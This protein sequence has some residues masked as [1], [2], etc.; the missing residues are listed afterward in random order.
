MKLNHYPFLR[1]AIF[2]ISGVAFCFSSNNHWLLCFGIALIALLV[3]VSGY[4]KKNK[5]LLSAGL[6]TLFFCLGWGV[7]W[8]SQNKTNIP[9][10]E[11]IE[12]Y[13]VR[14][15]SAVE[16]KPK[17]YKLTAEV[18]GLRQEEHWEEGNF[19]LLLYFEKD[20]S[21]VPVYGDIFLI[22]GHPR[23]IE[24]PKNPYEFNYRDVQFKKS[25]FGHHFLRSGD[26]V[27]LSHKPKSFLMSQILSWNKKTG[28]ILKHIT[29][30]SENFGIAESMLTGTRDNLELEI[31]DAYTTT[32]AVHILAVS[33]MHV[34]ILV[35]MLNFFFKPILKTPSSRFYFGVISTVCIWLYAVFTGFSASV[36]RATLMF[37]M[38][39]LAGIFYLRKNSLNIL[40]A[41]AVVL[42]LVNPVWFLDVG[43]Q[44]S[45]L[46]MIGIIYLYPQ[47]Y[48]LLTPKNWFTDHLWQVSVMS[49]TAQLFTTPVSLYY[50]HQFPNYFLLTNVL[51]TLGSSG[52]LLF[53]IP[54]VLLSGV[55]VINQVLATLLS[56]TLYF[57]NGLI[58]A[59]ASLPYSLSTG[60]NV[61]LT[62]VMVLFLMILLAVWLFTEKEHKL[63]IPLIILSVFLF[64]SGVFQDLR[65]MKQREITF[66]FIP[67]GSG[68]SLISSKKAL[69]LCDSV[70][71]INPRAYSF[72]L[73][74]YYDTKGI[75][76]YQFQSPENI[77]G[78]SSFDF[79]GLRCLWIHKSNTDKIDEYFDVVMISNNAVFDLEKQ[80][81]TMPK[82]IILDDTNSQKRIRTLE[83]QAEKLSADF[84]SLYETGGFTL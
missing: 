62:E 7:T 77:S 48:P 73:R 2:F 1:I 4:I 69:F 64:G 50:F 49:L 9:E 43:F 83:S 14:V 28:E 65:Q 18:L 21:R 57:M 23:T 80:F 72:H 44:L 68:I 12:A 56:W 20:S 33:G 6:Y 61:S 16:V 34:G 19:D 26:F 35:M 27:F 22:I 10:F 81:I 37:S 79:E 59:I 74:N 38:F 8:Q 67:K 63:L 76:Q 53:G 29:D 30:S 47:V 58:K 51:V 24:G 25:I 3:F 42:L 41:S 70:T 5:L 36:V 82:K 32:G 60:Y 54:A 17:S 11:E 66:H 46:A 55:P 84:I 31:K 40:A 75:Q 13:T 45:Y 71:K 52:V 78:F 15:K 39:Q